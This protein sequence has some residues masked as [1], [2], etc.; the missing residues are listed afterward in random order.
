MS[1][2]IGPENSSETTRLFGTSIIDERF[3]FYPNMLVGSGHGLP[4]GD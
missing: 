1:R 4:L 2:L 3:F